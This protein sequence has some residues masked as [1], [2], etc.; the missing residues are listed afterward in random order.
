MKDSTY[1]RRSEMVSTV[2]KSQATISAA[3]WCRNAR[4][5]VVVRRGTGSSP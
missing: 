3:C 4:E 2:K 5:V 1:S